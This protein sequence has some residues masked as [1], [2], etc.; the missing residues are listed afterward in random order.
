[1]SI[2]SLKTKPKA[3][4][5]LKEAHF[6]FEGAEVSYTTAEVGGAASLKNNA[7]LFKSM[8]QESLEGAEV[9]DN[10]NTGV[11]ADVDV[12]KSNEPDEET[13]TQEVIKALEAKVAEMEKQLQAKELAVK[14]AAASETFSKYGIDAEIVKELSEKYVDS[15]E[16]I[17]KALDAVV[18]NKDSE[19][20]K[21]KE[22]ITTETVADDIAKALTVE[23]GQVGEPEEPVQKTIQEQVSEK[24]KQKL[25][26]K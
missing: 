1:M 24:I 7:Y 5:V 23:K 6:D 11:I 19:I 15:V 21:V 8:Q 14:V 4:Y 9:L 26:I 16:T 18:A 13:M 3:Q 22:S 2:E 17:T 12:S 10:G 25:E 20:Q